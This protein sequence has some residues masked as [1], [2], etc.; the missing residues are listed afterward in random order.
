V[1][2]HAYAPALTI[3]EVT[4]NSDLSSRRRVDDML[5]AVEGGKSLARS[6]TRVYWKTRARCP[7]YIL[8]DL[9]GNFGLTETDFTR[10]G[11][12]EP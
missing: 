3:F 5:R 4:R 8:T 11:T 1:R 12:G 10:F 6:S 7:D 2:R 9:L